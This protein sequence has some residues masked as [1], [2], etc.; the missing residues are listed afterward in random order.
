VNDESA[1]NKSTS[2]FY[3]EGAKS[4]SHIHLGIHGGL[5]ISKNLMARLGASLF[6]SE[7]QGFAGFDGS[8]RYHI[9]PND[10]K[11]FIGLGGYAGDSKKCY[12]EYNNLTG[13]YDEICEKKFLY[14]AYLEA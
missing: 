2:G 13:R 12:R 9:L 10:I 11:P 1:A 14:A 3:L 7:G 5:E 8:L 6:F 4:G